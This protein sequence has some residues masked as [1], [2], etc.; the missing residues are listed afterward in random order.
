MTIIM[1]PLLC[2]PSAVT[3]IISCTA[4]PMPTNRMQTPMACISV[5]W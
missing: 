3:V 2:S 1:V 5:S 4:P